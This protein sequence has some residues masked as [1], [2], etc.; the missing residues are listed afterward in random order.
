VVLE[1]PEHLEIRTSA[2]GYVAVS[3]ETRVLDQLPFVVRHEALEHHRVVSRRMEYK[4]VAKPP[5]GTAMKLPSLRLSAPDFG[6]PGAPGRSLNNSHILYERLGGPQTVP[7]LN[8]DDAD[9]KVRVSAADVG[10]QLLVNWRHSH[11]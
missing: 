4:A 11:G 7:G 2:P 8:V 9:F 10:Q 1:E 6:L 3:I 5:S